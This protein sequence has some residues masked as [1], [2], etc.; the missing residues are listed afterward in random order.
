MN[1]V[2]TGAAGFIGS[3]LCERLVSL[4]H[5]VTGIDCFTDFYPREL[6]EQNIC[7]LRESP[8]FR[9]V[10]ADLLDLDLEEFLARAD[11]LFHQAAQA[12]VRPSWGKSFEVYTQQNILSTQRLL[13][14]AVNSRLKRFI[15]ASS[16]SVYG[17][18]DKLPMRE[19]GSLHPLS[20][21]GVTKLAA[22]Q[23]CYLYW[24]NFGVPV[25]SL[26]YFTVYGP[27][28]RPDMAF[29]RFIKAILAGQ[30]IP[31]YGDGEQTRDFTY[32]SDAVE[33]NIL[34]LNNG[35][36]GE[37]YN[38]GGGSRITIN[39]VLKIMSELIGRPAKPDYQQQQKGDMRHTYADVSKAEKELG[40]APRIA[41]EQGIEQEV[42][43][44]KGLNANH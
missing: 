17:A 20:P 18:T 33:A 13:E 3:H 39:R 1:C 31:V 32:I 24:R 12:G 36:T 7:R 40:Y 21:Y 2:V 42:A 22:E 4:G 28:Q 26:R 25:V 27:R 6:K 8:A 19:D 44:I 29:P 34:C 16:S 23:L 35:R 41:I 43:W 14:A 37:V 5:Q 30:S 10:E 9:F 11:C 38:I 15:Y